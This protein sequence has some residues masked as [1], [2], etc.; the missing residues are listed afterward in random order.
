MIIRS[1]GQI[2]RPVMFSRHGP[3]E[4]LRGEDV[5]VITIDRKLHGRKTLSARVTP[6]GLR[7]ESPEECTLHSGIIQTARDFVL[8]RFT[9][10]LPKLL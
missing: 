7:R 5:A 8:S 1:D 4:A 9:V 10:Y 3:D 2:V 6:K